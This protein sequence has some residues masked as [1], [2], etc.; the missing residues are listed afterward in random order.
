MYQC[1]N[2]LVSRDVVIRLKSL[3]LQFYHPARGIP[4]FIITLSRRLTVDD[5]TSISMD[6]LP[7][8]HRAIGASQENNHR[9]HL[10]RL[11]WSTHW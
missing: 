3:S 1:H 6:R 5:D 10:R 7:T 2:S 9:R 8:N 4:Y 11:A